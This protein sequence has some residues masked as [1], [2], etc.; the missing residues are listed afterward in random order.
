MFPTILEF[1]LVRLMPLLV[2][3]SLWF[4]P[5]PSA[6]PGC[7]H[8]I[9]INKCNKLHQQIITYATMLAQP[10]R[11]Q[12]FSIRLDNATFSPISVHAGEVSERRAAS[13]LTAMT[14]APVA[15][16]PMFTI[17]DIVRLVFCTLNKKAHTRTSFF[18]SFATLACLPSAVFTPS[19][20]RSR[21]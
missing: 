1:L 5:T 7:C 17:Y 14:F 18:A 8:C 19:S 10:I 2:C 6:V 4:L 21:K 20:L 12:C 16:E 11:R 13:A 15:V 9:N 3:P